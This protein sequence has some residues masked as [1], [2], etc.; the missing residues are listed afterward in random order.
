MNG[1]GK[2]TLL[3]VLLGLY[4]GHQG[5]EG[6]VLVN[7]IRMADYDMKTVYSRVAVVMQDFQRYDLTLR[8]NVGVGSIQ[9][10]KDR[11]RMKRALVRGGA[12]EL[13]DNVGLEMALSPWGVSRVG[14]GSLPFNPDAAKKKKAAVKNA[15]GRARNKDGTTNGQV[16][17]SPS[18]VSEIDD[19]KAAKDGGVEASE[20]GEALDPMECDPPEEGDEGGGNGD[21]GKGVSLPWKIVLRI[22]RF[23][24]AFVASPGARKRLLH[25]QIAAK[26]KRVGPPFTLSC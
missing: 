21:G 18:K 23:W 6:D 15:N 26:E 5:L 9:C 4:D 11:D 8:E 22:G 14:D 20:K 12:K 17:D 10:M 1:S 7:G 19:T 2:S 16:A 25:M 24:A 13:A 3:K